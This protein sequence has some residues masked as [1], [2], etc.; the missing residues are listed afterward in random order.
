MRNI[1]QRFLSFF[2]GKKKKMTSEQAIVK[3]QF[4]ERLTYLDYPQ[5][6]RIY[7][8]NFVKEVIPKISDF[9]WSAHSHRGK[10]TT[11]CGT[12]Y[13]MAP[14]VISSIEYSFNVDVWAIGVLAHEIT[15]GFLPYDGQR[16]QEIIKKIKFQ[17]IPHPLKISR[18]AWNF[19]KS[20]LH[21]PREK[22][23]SLDVVLRHPWLADIR[24]MMEEKEEEAQAEK[25]KRAHV[26]LIKQ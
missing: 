24:R 18:E 13:Y 23:P 6:R 16:D 14:E 8:R 21:S 15:T 7:P 3:R 26:R 5:R 17:K 10:K 19:I 4:I 1:K 11:Q 25:K 9:G 12:I 22:R 20:I 2:P